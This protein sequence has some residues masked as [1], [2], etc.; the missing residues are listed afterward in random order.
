MNVIGLLGKSV[1]IHLKDGGAFYLKVTG[2]KWADSLK[3]SDTKL[4]LTGMDEEG[5][6]ITVCLDDI[7]FIVNDGIKQ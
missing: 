5:E 2:Y 3:L 6:E 1:Q 7:E 4:Y